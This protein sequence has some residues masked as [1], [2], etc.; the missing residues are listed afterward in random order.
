MMIENKNYRD[1]GFYKEKIV[2]RHNKTTSDQTTKL[3]REL[4]G[5]IENKT[6]II[7][8]SKK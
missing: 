6:E 7:C 1:C 3:F 4:F 5:I 8:K 2:D